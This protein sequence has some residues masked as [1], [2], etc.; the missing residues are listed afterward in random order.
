MIAGRAGSPTTQMGRI[1]FLLPPVGP[2]NPAPDWLKQ[3]GEE[4][5]SET[6]QAALEYFSELVT[7]G[8]AVDT[9]EKL[10]MIRVV[11][12]ELVDRESRIKQLEAENAKLRLKIRK[13]QEVEDD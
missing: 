4:F 13:K 8:G 10:V 6:L 9:R 3:T 1:S 12:N 2:A 7:E 11:W 5:M